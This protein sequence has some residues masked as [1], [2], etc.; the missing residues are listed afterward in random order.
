LLRQGFEFRSEL[1]L[2]LVIFRCSPYFLSVLFDSC[3][4]IHVSVSSLHGWITVVDIKS[5]EGPCR[6]L[7]GGRTWWVSLVTVTIFWSWDDDSRLG[8][9]LG[10]LHVVSKALRT[11]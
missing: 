9:I 10:G 3:P 7:L 8:F 6:H 5:S 2:Y 11:G 1:T 4:S